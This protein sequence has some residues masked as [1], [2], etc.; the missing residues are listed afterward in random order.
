V[1]WS[2]GVKQSNMSEKRK[3]KFSDT[4]RAKYPNFSSGRNDHEAK[5]QVCDLYLSVANKGSGDLERHLTSERH[6][7]NIQK[8][9][10]CSSISN[11]FVPQFSKLDDKV[12]AAE[13]TMA[14]HTVSHHLSYRSND[15][16][17]ALYKTV[18]NDSETAKKY[19][20]A[21]TKTEAIINSVIAPHAVDIV[22]EI[23][24]GIS[25]FGLSVDGSNHGNQ[26]VFPILIQYFDWKSGVKTK[27][28]E[29]KTMPNETAQTISTYILET[30]K[31]HG[32]INKCVAFS[33]DNTN[34]NFG[35]LNRNPGENIFTYLK[36][37]L[38][39]DNLVGVG[40]PAHILHN[41][42]QH[43]CD[44]LSFDVDSI[45]M[46]I[47][48][49]FS[50]YTVRTEQLKEFCDSVDLHHKQLLKHCKTR[51]LSLFPAI[52]RIIKLYPA[53]KAYFLSLDK[54]PVIL[55][56]FFEN[57]LSEAYLWF[58]HSLM[59]VFHFKIEGAQ[60]EMISILEVVSYIKALKK[61]LEDRLE[62][63]FI[64]FKVRSILREV[65]GKGLDDKCDD[66][67]SEVT[68]VYSSCLDYLNKWTTN[69]EE[70][71]CFEWT[72]FGKEL[73]EA[74]FE[75][76]LPGVSYL[77]ERGIVIEDDKLFDQFQ[78]LKQFVASHSNDEDYFKQLLHLRWVDFFS[79][80]KSI[81]CFSELLKVC[82]FLFALPGTNSSI[83]RV[84]SN[85]NVQW[86]DERNK[87]DIESVKGI[88][89]VKYNFKDMTC[90]EFHK[91]LLSKPDLLRK[92][93]SKEKYLKAV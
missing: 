43:G 25:C 1:V 21:R 27:V 73:A 46:K 10:G 53:L 40:C 86:S 18:F 24:N 56:T 38:E 28:I 58:L 47:Y 13:G 9:S 17:S 30:L 64:S 42:I 76:V 12:S 23:M 4:L 54:P 84:F 31:K 77:Q 87:L 89:L 74:K 55:K 7:Q 62:E 5:C 71:K 29:L 92:I 39:N 68:S 57:D 34:T 36:S 60:K 70:F 48:N 59:S 41:T 20:S 93:S 91:Y 82:E 81:D 44:Q 37:G 85:I 32:L 35:G 83:E 66:F 72:N 90:V 2:S 65:R 11:F 88:I 22:I 15:C 75:D 80:C 16:T 50:I 79:Q 14:F 19:S 45:V 61:S 49:Y 51:W 26:K 33:G 69:L 6:K 8:S 3:C 78:C 67:I 63:K 52:E